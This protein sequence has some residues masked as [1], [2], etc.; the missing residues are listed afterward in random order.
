MMLDTL[1]RQTFVPQLNSAFGVDLPRAVPLTVE[2]IEVNQA[3]SA[4]GYE[5]FSMV[6]RGPSDAFL[7]QA[8]YRFHHE[9]LG[10]FDLF[11]VPVNQDQQGL[12]YEAVFNHR[13]ERAQA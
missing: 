7:P 9:A 8:T 1:S 10:T 6:F 3:R 2:L 11:I 13:C 5:A 12:Y 4:P